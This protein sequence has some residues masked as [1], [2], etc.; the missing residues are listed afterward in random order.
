[1][2]LLEID[3]VLLHTIR[4]NREYIV[5]LESSPE[6]NSVLINQYRLK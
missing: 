4:Q 2:E 6:E 5:T 3:P 1:M